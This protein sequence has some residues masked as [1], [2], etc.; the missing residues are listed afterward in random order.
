MSESIDD[1][2][3]NVRLTDRCWEWVAG[4]NGDGYG[5]YAPARYIKYHAHRYAYEHLKGPIPKGA[6]LHH[7]CRNKACVNPSY[8][9]AITPSQHVRI[10][11]FKNNTCKRSHVLDLNNTRISKRGHRECRACDAYRHRRRKG[12]R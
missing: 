10:E 1:F 2:F 7:V 11:K 12:A 8:L 3:K 6:H 5:C 9:I 4:K